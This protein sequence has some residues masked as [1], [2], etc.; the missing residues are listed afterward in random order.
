MIQ[1]EHIYGFPVIKNEKDGTVEIESN[2]D[3]PQQ[4][5][6]CETLYRGIDRQFI[7]IEKLKYPLNIKEWK[8]I[9]EPTEKNI[10]NYLSSDG[11]INYLEEIKPRIIDTK[12]FFKIEVSYSKGKELPNIILHFYQVN[13]E[14]KLNIRNADTFSSRCFIDYNIK[15][16]TPERISSLKENNINY[17]WIKNIPL[18]PVEMI[19]FNKDNKINKFKHQ[20]L[21]K[22]NFQELW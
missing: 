17:K 21:N 11:I 22:G 14:G 4:S 8:V 15:Q 5:V 2:C 18:F 7:E 3:Y 6:E 16:L 10:K 1:L 12:T 20:E 19:K 9:I 13:Y